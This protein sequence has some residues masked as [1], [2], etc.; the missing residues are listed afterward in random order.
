MAHVECQLPYGYY[1]T[2]HACPMAHA[3][4][5]C[6]ILFPITLVKSLNL[7]VVIDVVNSA[8]HIH[9]PI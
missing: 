8:S 6:N 2:E 3:T 4:V 9:R 7:I 1:R 5:K